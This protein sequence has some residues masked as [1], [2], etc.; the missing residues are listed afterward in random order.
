MIPTITD[1]SEVTTKWLKRLLKQTYNNM[2]KVS[3]YSVA[4]VIVCGHC[5]HVYNNI[6]NRIIHTQNKYQAST[7]EAEKCTFN[8]PPAD[9]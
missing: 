9:S 6:V 8:V 7:I 5:I 4:A 1:I 3:L 2:I